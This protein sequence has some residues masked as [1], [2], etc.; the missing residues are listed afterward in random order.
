MRASVLG[1]LSVRGTSTGLRVA[2]IVSV[3]VLL[4]AARSL[5]STVSYVS[6]FA[7]AGN[8]DQVPATLT[9]V[10]LDKPADSDESAP[11]LTLRYRYSYRGEDHEGNRLTLA[12]SP[13]Y[14]RP[15]LEETGKR[16]AESLVT[17][18]LVD[19]Y[20][21]PTHPS[22]SVLD[23]KFL[24]TV[25][26]C[27]FGGF[28]LGAAIGGL[29]LIVPTTELMRRGRIDALRASSPGEP[30]R[31][32]EDWS[33]GRIRSASR[34]D[35]WILVGLAVGYL[36]I[37]LPLG[38]L[39]VKEHGR[40]ILSVPGGVL[41]VGGWAAFN[42]ARTRLW[43]HRRFDGSVFQLAGQTGVIGGPIYGSI[44]M[45]IKLPE[46]KPVRLSLECITLESVDNDSANDHGRI[47]ERVLWRDSQLLQHTLQSGEA[48]LT[49]IPVYFAI[50][51]DCKASQPNG[52]PAIQWYLKVGP[53]G[54]AGLAEYAAFEV[55][56][57]ETSDSSPGFEADPE[58]MSQFEVPL[59]LQAVLD[60]SGCVIQRAIK[61]TRLRFSL[62]R[63]VP[64]LQALMFSGFLVA[65]ATVLII[66]SY[67]LWA[68]LPGLL[69]AVVLL[70]SADR[71]L[72]RSEIR[73][74]DLEIDAVAG[75]W[76]FRK[77]LAINRDVVTGVES[78]VEFAM[79]ERS[80][81]SVR[82]TALI[83]IEDEFDDT[84]ERVD[85]T[86]E[87]SHEQTGD[88]EQEFRLE[89]LVVARGL[90]S[91]REAKLLSQWLAEQLQV[92]RSL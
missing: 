85:P 71:F 39:V 60:R 26:A 84:D 5:L 20:V 18:T 77:R 69:A 28:I 83:P 7:R 92:T 30:W 44:A 23:R 15:L 62:F 22:S 21:D 51:Y 12:G 67:D 65:L 57:F 33:F 76:G 8:W 32:R 64:V 38:L 82:L 80:S 63:W 70:A 14:L 90:S 72:W 88:L 36:V 29:L 31:W 37:V 10:T 6:E 13:F 1:R 73:A 11:W 66:F 43:S 3:F 75:L 89:V 48:N 35:S 2:Q 4:F 49:L 54:G 52:N 17:Q 86:Q 46:G 42:L 34:V 50:P 41:I 61:E 74:N 16:L 45:P 81:Y 91:E 24:V 59:E 79:K 40:E 55:P 56:V 19:C 27:R 87:F 53:E 47:E 78:G 68:I 25:V 9:E 58:V